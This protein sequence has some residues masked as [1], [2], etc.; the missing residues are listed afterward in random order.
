[1]F[2][3]LSVLWMG[4]NKLPQCKGQYYFIVIHSVFVECGFNKP[5]SC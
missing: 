3:L 4:S 5:L 2:S 1:V